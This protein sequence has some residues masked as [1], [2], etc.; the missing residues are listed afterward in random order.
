[1]SSLDRFWN[2]KLVLRGAT[3]DN[4]SADSD[5]EDVDLEPISVPFIATSNRVHPHQSADLL[6]EFGQLDDVIELAAREVGLEQSSQQQ[7]MSK[8]PEPFVIPTPAELDELPLTELRSLR[9]KLA[10]EFHPDRASG[11]LDG[12]LGQ[13]MGR[14]NCLIDDA[15]NRKKHQAGG[16]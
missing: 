9:R 12:G 4:R 2:F 13:T 11:R 7:P 15:I 5:G 3:A 8:L 14:C 16:S 1:M 6:E 10:L